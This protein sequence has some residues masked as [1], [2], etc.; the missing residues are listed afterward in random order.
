MRNASMSNLIRAAA[1]LLASAVIPS[2][3]PVDALNATISTEGLTIRRD[4]AYA[5]G[6]RG[7][8]DVYRPASTEK[9]PL[10]VFIYGGAWRNGSK[11]DYKFVAA[12]LARQGVVVAVPDYRL[13]PE[14]RFPTFLEDN[15]S[16][17]A[18][19]RAH[20]AEWGADPDHLFLVGHSAGAYDAVMLAL[21]PHY[22]GDVGIDRKS[23]SGVVGIASPADF[24]PL[25][26][27][28]T[29]AAFGQAP[30]LNL[31]QPV[32]FADGANPPLL[33]LH[34]ES[35]GTVYPR[36]SISLAQRIKAAG[37]DVTLKLYPGIGHVGI[38]TSFAPLFDGRAPVMADVMGF[39]HSH[40]AAPGL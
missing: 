24:L 9:L 20:A 37:G 38:V 5:A 4:I 6:P 13:V 34:G 30:D 21:D 32:H 29:I 33:L 26:D 27:K 17:V 15:A 12:P 19:A 10:V 8:M 7:T 2:C 22:L 11:N 1:V 16:A 39:I 14:V 35:D 3:A 40:A 28:D 18:F 31:T 25:D 36:N 23:L